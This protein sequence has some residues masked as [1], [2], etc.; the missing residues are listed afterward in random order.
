VIPRFDFGSDEGTGSE[1]E[2]VPA[3]VKKKRAPAK[4]K[5]YIPSKGSGGYGILLG[6]VLAIERPDLGCQVFLTRT[7][8]IRAAQPYSNSSYDHS[9][10]GGFHTAWASMKTLVT[11]GYVYVTG[12][13]HKY[14]LTEEG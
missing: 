12:N 1:A 2:E 13:P 4:P 7:E 9:E 6:L 8:L 5:P 11:K 3:S 14:A 10:K